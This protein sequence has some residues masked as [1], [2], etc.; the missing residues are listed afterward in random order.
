M[1]TGLAAAPGARADAWSEVATFG[2]WTV[3]RNHASTSS[4]T[5]CLAVHQRYAAIRLYNDQLQIAVPETPRGYQYQIDSGAASKLYLAS[6]ADQENA[7]VSL[8]GSLL[9]NLAS[10]ERVRVEILTYSKILEVDL[11][12]N[13]IDDALAYLGGAPSCRS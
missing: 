13:G 3:V 7:T 2:N 11:D 12:L 10:S 1:A 6:Q 8:A 9:T 5:Q 4:Q